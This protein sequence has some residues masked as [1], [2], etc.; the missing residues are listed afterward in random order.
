MESER[1]F[2]RHLRLLLF[3]CVA[4]LTHAP[5]QSTLYLN[6]NEIANYPA[7][8]RIAPG[9][10]AMIEFE[11]TIQSVTKDSP[12]F[13]HIRQGNIVFLSA[14]ATVD[15]GGMFVTLR[16]TTAQFKIVID[17]TL[18]TGMKYL[19]RSPRVAQPKVIDTTGTTLNPTFLEAPRGIVNSQ[20]DSN[21]LFDNT[22]SS[23]R[24]HSSD[25]QADD[26]QGSSGDEHNVAVNPV[27]LE[28]GGEVVTTANDPTLPFVF[29]AMLVGYNGER[30]VAYVIE[31]KSEHLLFN[32]IKRLS[33]TVDGVRNSYET[34]RRPTGGYL[35]RLE[36]KAK[37]YGTIVLKDDPGGAITLDWEIVETPANNTYTIHETLEE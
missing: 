8:V 32:D 31:N 9:Y 11:E 37:E 21:L 2:M 28:P 7:D 25:P 13:E 14:K 22:A 20:T 23:T 30:T 17:T 36:P 16:S 24:E 34:L 27:L 6:L 1:M 18:T 33:V 29:E 3:L 12:L 19:V 15:G 26:D 5:A 35:N 10:P 4:P